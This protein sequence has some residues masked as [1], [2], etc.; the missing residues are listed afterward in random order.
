M[1]L[2][3]HGLLND[4]VS[5]SGFKGISNVQNIFK[6]QA[7]QRESHRAN[8]SFVLTIGVEIHHHS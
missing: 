3:N 1:Y 7:L 2:I 8:V 4:A 5:S 6:V